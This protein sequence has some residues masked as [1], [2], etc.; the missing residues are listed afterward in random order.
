MKELSDSHSPVAES[1]AHAVSMGCRPLQ[2]SSDDRAVT[3]DLNRE[4]RQLKDLSKQAVKEA[5]DSQAVL[6]PKYLTRR[7]IAEVLQVT[8]RTVDSLMDRGLLP[9][10][11]VGRE[12]RFRFCDVGS[13]LERTRTDRL[14]LKAKC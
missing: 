3:P 7:Q 5:L 14:K 2:P 13:Q 9:Y 8:Q 6:P 12:V 1:R 4:Q 10:L 11:R